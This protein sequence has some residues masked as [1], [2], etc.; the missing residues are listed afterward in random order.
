[1]AS[2]PSLLWNPVV[3]ILS[4][5]DKR[6]WVRTRN[7]SESARAAPNVDR[8]RQLSDSQADSMSNS[9]CRM[10]LRQ[11]GAPRGTNWEAVWLRRGPHAASAPGDRKNRSKPTRGRKKVFE[12]YMSREDISAGLKR[13]MLIQVLKA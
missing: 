8:R 9:D 1:M 2:P 5:G 13:K 12:A 6:G 3:L 11:L 10:N 4:G 7:D